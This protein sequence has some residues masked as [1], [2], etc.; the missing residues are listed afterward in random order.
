[1]NIIF[2]IGR[3]IGN[4]FNFNCFICMYGKMSKIWEE[5]DEMPTELPLKIHFDTFQWNLLKYIPH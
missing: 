2:Q 1:M 3:F 5:N 4:F